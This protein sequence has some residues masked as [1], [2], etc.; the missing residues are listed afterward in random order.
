VLC[1]ADPAQLA[2]GVTRAGHLLLGVLYAG[3]LI[4]HC[5]LLHRVSDGRWWVVFTIVVVMAS[6]T[7]G[8]FVGGALGR[9]RLA[10]AISPKK[11]VEGAAGSLAAALLAAA[12]AHLTFFPRADWAEALLLGAALGILGQLGD[13]VESVLKRAFGTKDSGWIIPGHGGILDRLDSLVF[14]VV[15]S[16]YYAVVLHG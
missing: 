8:Y 14:P 6:D 15:F 16:Y 10:E 12:V 4:P 5:V 11:T 13:L 3:F 1:L 2:A 7:G 9:H